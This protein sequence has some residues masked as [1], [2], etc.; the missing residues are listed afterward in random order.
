ME[1]WG[2]YLCSQLPVSTPFY[3]LT[4]SISARERERE[5]GTQRTRA[6]VFPIHSPLLTVS[7]AALHLSLSYIL[8]RTFHPHCLDSRLPTDKKRFSWF[9]HGPAAMAY[10]SP[11]GPSF[12]LY[13][14]SIPLSL[15]PPQC[16]YTTA[17]F[18]MHAL[19]LLHA[20][21]NYTFLHLQ[22]V[23]LF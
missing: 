16:I 2:P 8:H 17:L 6:R 21:F 5:K 10:P 3:P 23:N 11:T 4:N 12:L 9:L 18:R 15:S 1:I 13:Q 7:P 22:I 19:L 14:K 20:S